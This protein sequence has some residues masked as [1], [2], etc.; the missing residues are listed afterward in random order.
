VRYFRDASPPF[1]GGPFTRSLVGGTSRAFGAPNGLAV[2]SGRVYVADS[3]RRRIE[4]FSLPPTRVSET[5]T[6]DRVPR[7][8]KHLEIALIGPSYTFWDSLGDDSICGEIEATLNTPARA[9]KPARCHAIRIDD[10][11]LPQVADYLREY[12]EG[13][14]DV[15]AILLDDNRLRGIFPGGAVPERSE[16]RR[17][18]FRAFVTTSLLPAIGADVRTTLLWVPLPWE[19]SNA[20]GL[21][22]RRAT[23]ELAALTPGPSSDAIARDALASIVGLPIVTGD[24]FSAALAHERGVDPE[25]IVNSDDPH[26]RPAG[27]RF[28]A[29]GELDLL[30]RTGAFGAMGSPAPAR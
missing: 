27:N 5:G 8:G 23:T 14:F 20:E 16:E 30:R 1:V 4:S 6:N 9:G 13:R 25:L 10:G 26:P 12:G 15:V 3:Q 7:D 18:A 29:R 21:F 2:G 19:V 28:I 17:A 24:L 11:G 22:Y